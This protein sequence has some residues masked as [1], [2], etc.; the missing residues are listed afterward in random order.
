MPTFFPN[1]PAWSIEFKEDTSNQ[2]YEY[3]SRWCKDI[4][5]HTRLNDDD[6]EHPTIISIDPG[7]LMLTG[8]DMSP[9]PAMKK[10]IFTFNNMNTNENSTT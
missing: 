3:F 2:I 1:K 4:E 9:T 5:E 10:F 6:D 8:V 7:K